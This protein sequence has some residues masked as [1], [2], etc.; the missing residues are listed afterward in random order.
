MFASSL[1]LAAGLFAP[2]S[3]QSGLA[4]ESL[5]PVGNPLAEEV[6]P[7]ALAR[8][9]A[10]VAGFVEEGE[11][12]GGELLV[13]KNGRTLLRSAHGW[14]DR[15]SETLLE[16]GGVY[17]VRSMTKSLIGTA[18]WMLIDERE[19]KAS[20]PI[21][22]YLPAYDVDGLREITVGMLLRHR[23]GFPF[24]LM[25][26]QDLSSF[27]TIQEVAA[28]AKPEALEFTPGER[29]SYSDHSSDTLAA[30]ID[31]VAGVSVAEFVEQRLLE[32]LGMVDSTTL[33][34]PEHALSDRAV[35]RYVGTPGEWARYWQPGDA[36]LFQC[37]LG[38]QGLHAT[39][40]DY[41]RFCQLWLDKGRW[42][43]ERRLKSRSVRKAL[44]PSDAADGIG[45]PTGFPG[46]RTD[47]GDHFQLWTTAPDAESGEREVQV[48][49]HTGSDG[50]HAWIFP[51]QDAMAFY[52]TQSRGTLSGLEVEEAL[53]EIFLGAPFDPNQAAPPLEDYLGL[54]W[55]GPG[56]LHRAIVLDGGKLS[57][58]VLGKTVAEL[59]YVGDDR[60][61]I[62][63]EPNN[64]LE[65]QRDAAGSVT[66]FRIGDHQELRFDP[67]GELP[68]VDDIVERLLEV[69]GMAKYAEHTPLRVA[70]VLDLQGLKLEGTAETWFDA[71]N[72]YRADVA[73]AANTESVA[74]DGARVTTL[75]PAGE[76]IELEGQRGR[77]AALDQ[78]P[79]RFGDWRLHYE[80]LQVV[81]RMEFDGRSLFLV[82]A[83][84]AGEP[85]TVFGVDEAT[86]RL[87]REYGQVV[88]DQ[89]GA[90]GRKLEFGDFRPMG[91][92]LVPFKSMELYP[93][94]F[95]G[96]VVADITE[97]ELR[98]ELPQDWLKLGDR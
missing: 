51:D 16:P 40:V 30:V 17:C 80:H 75:N 26:G 12:V 78:M 19:L 38:S 9:D 77:Q 98:S 53:A 54:Y 25:M 55:E 63:Q 91:E 88:V 71:P 4:Q 52:F 79:I 62:R 92:L 72:H 49:G 28:L 18:I 7:E 23:G 74:Y 67:D 97:F 46:L 85:C 20:D 47:Y 3:T 65:F 13:I 42:E 44:E 76:L 32:P 60:W 59:R 70:S 57:L 15:E 95:I 48:F 69:H 22:K 1:L 83:G 86:G 73:V 6:S 61:K 27:E 35:S 81:Q 94:P 31:V 68:S 2:V 24:S 96:R 8:L 50:T 10:L 33:L 45:M 93:T 90:M 66:G 5:F 89:L 41:A 14:S 84:V 36:S 43:G 29:F 64:V 58:E 37:F 21:A 82:R 39:T 87:V 11:I 56:D 34:T